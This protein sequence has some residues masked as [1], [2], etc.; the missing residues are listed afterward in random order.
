MRLG[1]YDVIEK[2]GEGGMGEVWRARDERLNRSVALKILPSEVANDPIRR[3]RFE[4]EARALGAL[5]HPNIVAVYDAGQDNGQAYIVS[6]LVDGESLRAVIERGRLPLKKVIDYAVQISDA[7]AAAHAAG[8]VHRDLKPENVMIARD[9]RV[10]VLDFGLAKQTTA[11]PTENTATLALSQPGMVMG[12]V[13]YMSPEQVRGETLD[14]RSDIFSFGCVLYEMITGKRAFQSATPVESMHA[15]L[16]DDPPELAPDQ[17]AIPPALAGILRR[18]L[19]KRPEQR[20][21]SAADLAF[22]LRS[23]T[24]SSTSGMQPVMGSADRKRRGWL[25]PL[26]GALGGIL[27]LAAGFLFGDFTARREPPNFQRITFRKGLVTNARFTADGR[28]VVYSAN[29]DGGKGRV[30]LAIPGNPESRDLDL[31]D[32]SILLSVSST[33]EIAFLMGPYGKDGS[34]TLSRS[35]ISGGQMRPW[36]EGVKVADWAPDGST[37]A[38]FRSVNGKNR[39]EYPIGHL[40]LET[41]DLPIFG[42]RVSPDGNRIVYAHYEHNSSIALD[43]I[44]RS[45]KIQTLGMVAGQTFELVDP[46]LNWSPNGREVWFRSFDAKEW[47][48]IYALDLSGH[49]RVVTRIPGHATVYDIAR[50]GRLLLRTDTRQVGILGMGPGEAIERDLSCLDLAALNGISDDGRVIVATIIGESGGPKG[51]VYLRKTDGSPPIRLGDGVA[52]AL[53]PDGNWVSG[54]YAATPST[55]QYVVLPTGAGEV[56]NLSIPGLAAALLVVYG[57]SRDDQT[58][59]LHSATKAGGWRLQNFAWDSNSGAVRP[60]GPS[61]VADDLPMLSPDRTQVLDT[62]P[63]GRW[64][65]FPVAGGEGRAVAGLSAHDQVIG[66]REDNRSIYISAHHD[67]NQTI[68]ISVLDTVSGQKTPWK[69]LRASRPVDEAYAPRITPDGRAYA[70]NFR[71]KLSDL[72]IASGLR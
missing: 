16:H 43:V 15:I 47:G 72:Y 70:Y 25:V 66:W 40:L 35:S 11:A 26:L 8:I 69:E 49:R 27:L 12:T 24:S 53:S 21:Q 30:Y 38:V 1:N 64:W 20:F 4:Q 46:V 39:L 50:D 6:E 37:M 63:D 23:I 68:P 57:W 60:F 34:G 14:H 45:G 17:S 18:C 13:G 44:D 56:R 32:G 9:G 41:G 58:M 19:E 67:V 2:L 5:N 52:F 36:L 33:E 3:A 42:M 61:R 59:F 71:V 65:I 55:R 10:K 48:T 51:S 28:N 54:Y 62:G 31:P 29:W 22:A 7:L